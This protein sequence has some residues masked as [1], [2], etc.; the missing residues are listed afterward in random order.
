MEQKYK[1]QYGVF[2][3]Q[4]EEEFEGKTFQWR[5]YNNSEKIKFMGGQYAN[6][7]EDTEDIKFYKSEHLRDNGF[8]KFIERQR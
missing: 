4:A 8:V 2:E 7:C 3:I 6:Y 1:D 5:K